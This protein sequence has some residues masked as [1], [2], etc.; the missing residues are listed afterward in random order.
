MKIGF[1]KDFRPDLDDGIFVI[2][3]RKSMKLKGQLHFSNGSQKAWFFFVSAGKAFAHEPPDGLLPHRP[4]GRSGD[5]ERLNASVAPYTLKPRVFSRACVGVM[6]TLAT[7]HLRDKPQNR[8]QPLHQRD[9]AMDSG[10]HIYFIYMSKILL[11]L[12]KIKSTFS[13]TL[14]KA[15]TV[16]PSRHYFDMVTTVLITKVQ[17]ISIN[18]EYFVMKI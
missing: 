16:F 18:N 9:H 11:K 12:D 5:S 3:K 8:D 4:R 10:S 2:G 15:S 6:D 13:D 14:T 17:K 1:V 7:K